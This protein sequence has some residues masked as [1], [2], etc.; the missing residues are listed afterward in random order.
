MIKRQF[1]RLGILA[2][3]FIFLFTGI[4]YPAIAQ[5]A[6]DSSQQTQNLPQHERPIPFST[7]DYGRPTGDVAGAIVGKNYNQKIYVGSDPDEKYNITLASG[8]SLPSGLQLQDINGIS[9]PPG[10]IQNAS[11]S[12]GQCQWF[13]SYC[14]WTVQRSVSGHRRY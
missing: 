5:N 2:L 13:N 7:I 6:P 10:G 14:T 1:L 9:A 3:L 11:S 8:W 4:T 12:G